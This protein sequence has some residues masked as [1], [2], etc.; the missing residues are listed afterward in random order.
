MP[1]K[2][3]LQQVV[4][5]EILD[6]ETTLA[7]F[8]KDASIF[9]IKP[10]VVIQPK[11]AQDIKN[12]V[13][14]VSSHRDQKLSITP[15]SA[16]TCMSGGAINDSIILDM[17]KHFNQVLE[18]GSDFAITQPGVY[19]RDFEKETL[20]KDLLLPCYTASRE[21]N[22]VGGMVGNNSAGEK[23]LSYGQTERYVQEL[24]IIF[25]DGNEY[26]VSPLTKEQLDKKIAQNDFEGN[27][28]KSV[29]K[30][31]DDNYDALQEAKPTTSKNSAGYYLWNV[32]DKQTFDLNKLLVGSQGTLGV[33]TEI[34][35]KLVKPKKHSELVVIFL[36]N[37]EELEIVV[38][39]VLKH[40]PESFESYDDYTLKVAVKF[41]PELFKVIKPKNVLSL[42]WEF[43]P[44]VWMSLTGGMPK[45]VL[46]AEFTG[47]S[48]EEVEQKCLNCQED[49]KD[50]KLKTRIT[51]SEQEAK[52]YWTMRRESFNLL[53]HHAG[54]LRTA[55]FIDDI[56]VNPKFL[57]EFLP[58]LKKLLDSYKLIYTV[59][60]HIGNGNFHIIPL[61]DLKNPKSADTIKEV[62]G[63]VYDLVLEYHGSTAAEHN[64]GL[65]RGFYLKQMYGEKIYGLFED[66]KKIFDPEDIFNPHKKAEAQMDYSFD[67]ISKN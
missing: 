22:T 60:G 53:R 37:I 54:N 52:K 49:L 5:G 10:Q 21:I 42:M 50:L 36:H 2:Q 39:R 63:K 61:M 29:Y 3:A 20:K 19:Y 57:P 41:L 13:K 16:G 40:Q 9:E 35:F 27:I 56:I 30:L 51:K 38:N 65:V 34:K 64:D 15:R 28:Y 6:D 44:E 48:L 1:I 58:K 59:A 45:L 43:L 67:H 32:W 7:T 14:Y 33:V 47:D 46:L 12:L 18:V 26:T 4:K 31:I 55:P 25:S 23:T 66:V 62:S 17:T 11:D 24:K 8:S